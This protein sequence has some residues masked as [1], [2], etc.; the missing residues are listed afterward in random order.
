M[1]KCF[2]VFGNWYKQ[3]VEERCTGEKGGDWEKRI[4]T[5]CIGGSALEGRSTFGGMFKDLVSE[6]RVGCVGRALLSKAAAWKRAGWC[7]LCERGNAT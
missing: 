6:R 5:V 3:F 7:H 4:P 2:L 1:A